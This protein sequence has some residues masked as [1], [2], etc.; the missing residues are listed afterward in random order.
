MSQPSIESTIRSKLKAHFSIQILEI[1]N[2][3]PN[4]QGQQAGDETHFRILIV[5]KDFEGLN[6]VKRHQSV[7]QVLSKEL[8]GPV[9]AFSQKTLT[10]KEWEGLGEAVSPS[11]PCH[12]RK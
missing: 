3:S 1:I 6:V 12:N 4:H 2:E 5:S 11:P 8:K 10:P 7:Y 9:H